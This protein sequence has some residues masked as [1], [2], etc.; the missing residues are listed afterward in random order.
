VSVLRGPELPPALY[1]EGEV[2]ICIVAGLNYV[3]WSLVKSTNSG[4]K[5]NLDTFQVIFYV[6]SRIK[7]RD[8]L[9]LNESTNL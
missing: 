3:S 1:L 4:D 7:S 2:Q 5:R 6:Q 9:N 8:C